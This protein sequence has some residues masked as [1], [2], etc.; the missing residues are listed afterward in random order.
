LAFICCA[1][2]DSCRWL[3]RSR[4]SP[5]VNIAP[6]LLVQQFSWWLRN[7]LIQWQLGGLAAVTAPMHSLPDDTNAAFT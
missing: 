1:K 6:F 2:I 5:D 3:R 4:V 7:A